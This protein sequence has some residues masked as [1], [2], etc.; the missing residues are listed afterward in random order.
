MAK[1]VGENEMRWH[2]PHHQLL[3]RHLWICLDHLDDLLGYL[4][5]DGVLGL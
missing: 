1:S 4:L 2:G 5:I 3:E